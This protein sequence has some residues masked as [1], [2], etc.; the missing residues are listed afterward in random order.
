M[1]LWA[2]VLKGE[3]KI[4]LRE[5]AWVYGD[6]PEEWELEVSA[7]VARPGKDIDG[8]L[9]VKFENFEVEWKKPGA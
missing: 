1:C 8:D 6:N 9:E 2:Y 5:I 4:P 7:A 3:E